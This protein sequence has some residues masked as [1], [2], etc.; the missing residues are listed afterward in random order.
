MRLPPGS[1]ARPSFVELLDLGLG[2]DQAR[3]RHRGE[4]V[5]ADDP[6]GLPLRSARLSGWDAFDVE[7]GARRPL[8]EPIGGFW[9]GCSVEGLVA[10]GTARFFERGTVEAVINGAR[11]QIDLYRSEDGQSL[12]TTFPRFLG[13]A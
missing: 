2:I 7:T 11:Y 10:L 12:R 6:D 1:S 4:G 8:M 3:R 9:I 13:L 5:H